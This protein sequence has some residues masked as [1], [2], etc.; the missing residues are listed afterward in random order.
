MKLIKDTY[1]YLQRFLAKYY[2]KFYPGVEVIGVTGSVGKTT[3]KEMIAA[4]L[5]EKYQVLATKANIDPIYNI[6]LT[7]FKLRPGIEKFIVELSVDHFGDMDKYF[8]MVAPKVGVFT[9]IY[10][11]HT[12]FLKN[13]DGVI[14]EKGRLA[15]VLPKDGWLILNRDDDNSNQIAKKTKAKILYYGL[16]PDCD[17]YA[18]D[19]KLNSLEEINFK[20]V[21]M[22][23]V[24]EVK[25]D[26]KSRDDEFRGQEIAEIAE[27][28]IRLKMLGIQNIYSALAA[29]AIGRIS[30]LSLLEIKTG[31]EKMRPLPFRMNLT[32]LSNGS[33]LINDSYSSNP[34]AT[35]TAIQATGQLKIT[36]RRIAVLGEMKEL[37]DYGESG[38][39]EVGRSLVE[40]DFKIL[41]VFGELTKYISEEIKKNGIKIEIFQ[42]KTIEEIIK[43]LSRIVKGGDIILLKGSRFTHMERIALGLFGRKISCH[44]IT[45]QFYNNCEKCKEI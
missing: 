3:T 7:I 12:E 11:T 29:A 36:G 20:I 19:L 15:E 26:P 17:F 21:D 37:G 2:L 40:N 31:L 27:I 6:P 16:T 33:F 42:A 45:C 18:K 43:I 22:R 1:H 4:V 14:S 39:R 38:H 9:P 30:G 34:L 24:K 44:K 35:K 8:W 28:E 41:I 13:L 10:F 32:K 5:S 25:I 23:L